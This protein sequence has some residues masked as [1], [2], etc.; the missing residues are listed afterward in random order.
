LARQ[1]ALTVPLLKEWLAQ[2]PG[3]SALRP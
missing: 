3:A 1:R 2:A